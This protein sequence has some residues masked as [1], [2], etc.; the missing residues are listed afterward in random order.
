MAGVG[1]FLA[2]VV[3]LV[4]SDPAARPMLSLLANYFYGYEVSWTGAW[5]GLAEGA[6][7][8]G[9]VGWALGHLLNAVIGRE[10]RRLEAHIERVRA[11]ELMEGDV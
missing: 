10:R 6:V 7:G 3:L 9:A 4:Q 8:G 1:L 2:T 5:I 11:V